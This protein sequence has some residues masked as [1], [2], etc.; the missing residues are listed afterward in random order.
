[1]IF[2]C[3]NSRGLLALTGLSIAFAATPSH[4]A[5]QWQHNLGE[6]MTLARRTH[7]PIMIDFYTDWCV[8][9]KTLDQQTYP[10]A[11]V[12]SLS[13]KFVMVKLNAET[14][15]LAAATQLN[16][17]SYPYLVFLD[18]PNHR[19]IARIDGYVGPADLAQTMTQVL[20]QEKDTPHVVDLPAPALR[21]RHKRERIAAAPPAAQPAA[22]QPGSPGEL[23]RATV[24][25]AT[26]ISPPA[27]TDGHVY[28]LDE[29][30]RKT[31]ITPPNSPDVHG[32][33]NTTVAPPNGT[34]SPE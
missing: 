4:A 16:V 13:R 30:G 17:T 31:D 8:W 9:S 24:E 6:A 26:Q 27:P 1:M 2:S 33:A 22:P 12:Q 25:T 32:P 10:D 5:V 23:V 21:H 18:V 19:L 14:D 7:R 34:W 20:Q 3:K 28:L 11:E 15:G 29:S